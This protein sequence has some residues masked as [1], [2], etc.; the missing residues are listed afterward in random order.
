LFENRS[1][2]AQS[3]IVDM[4]KTTP[5]SDTMLEQLVEETES[6]WYAHDATTEL[7]ATVDMHSHLFELYQHGWAREE[8]VAI[9]VKQSSGRGGLLLPSN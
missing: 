6:Y 5:L 9:L 7:Q 2:I 4:S 1:K 3:A 8:D